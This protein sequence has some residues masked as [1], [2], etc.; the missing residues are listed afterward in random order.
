MTE[1]G[2]LHIL[3]LLDE[4]EYRMMKSL[5]EP[6]VDLVRELQDELDVAHTEWAWYKGA[7]DLE[8]EKLSLVEEWLDRQEDGSETKSIDDLKSGLLGLRT[9]LGRY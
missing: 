6:D 9:I 4:E 5:E 1:D 2:L 3:A 8:S 7:Y